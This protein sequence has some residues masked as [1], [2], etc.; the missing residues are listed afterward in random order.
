MENT[1]LSIYLNQGIDRI[2]KRVIDGTLTNPK[3]TAFLLRYFSHS[4]KA[5]QRRNEWENMGTHIPAFLIASIT[6]SCNLHCKGCYARDN[7]NCSDHTEKT[8]L[9]T[10]DW[11]KAFKEAR[12]LGI[13]FI[14][15]AGGEPLVR[16]D[17][18]TVAAKIPQI[19]F[20]IFTNGTLINEAYFALFDKKRNLVPIISI[21][22]TET[23]TDQRRGDGVYRNVLA[24]MEQLKEKNILFGISIT[25][26][27]ENIGEVTS[28]SFMETMA[29]L[30]CQLVFFIEY[31]PTDPKTNHL[32][33]TDR[34]RSQLE[35]RQEVLRQKFA[36]VLFLS[37][38]GD[39]DKMGGCIAAGRGFFHINPYGAAEAC[40]FSPYS[41]RTI[42]ETSLLEVLD[43]PFFKKLR[44]ERLVG[45]EHS[46]GCALFE[47][48][49]AVRALLEE[50]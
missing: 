21:E 5:K 24:K 6:H 1:E 22:G 31:V 15:L 16:P 32:A 10:T 8:M 49:S 12:N 45:G 25:V 35:E 23:S 4:K 14:I 34:E 19:I 36:S 28:D 33:F 13:G 2:I 39:E 42:K 26:T 41:D 20:P 48:E 30:G 50:A 47:Q 43:S 44:L 7:G 27:T 46:G 17:V 38:P 29:G 37:F 9:G 18:L 3:E 11:E 40:P